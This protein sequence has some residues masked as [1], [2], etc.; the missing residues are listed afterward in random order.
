MSSILDLKE[1]ILSMGGRKDSDFPAA[2][3]LKGDER[4]PILQDNANVLASVSELLS[5]GGAAFH[6]VPPTVR[7]INGL[8]DYVDRNVLPSQKT[9]GSIFSYF[10]MDSGLWEVVRYK[11]VSTRTEDIKDSKNWEWLSV[12]SS[13]FK[14]LFE[15]SDRLSAV[16]R[17]PKVGDHA[18]VGETMVTS[19]LYKCK[20]DGFWS[21][22][23]KTFEDILGVRGDLFSEETDESVE[24]YMPYTA[25]MA[26]ADDDGNIISQTY[27]TRCMLKDAIQKSKSQISV[28]D[29]STELLTFLAGVKSTGV[30]VNSED[31]KFDDINRLTFA[32]RDESNEDALG[33]GYIYMRRNIVD[34]INLLEQRM[35]SSPKTIYNIR[36][37]YDL[38]GGTITIPSN[39]VL[40]FTNGGSFCNGKVKFG[41]NVIVRIF[42]RDQL[43]V[44]IEGQ[45]FFMEAVKMPKIEVPKPVEPKMKNENGVISFSSD[46]GQTWTVLLDTNTLK[47]KIKAEGR[48]IKVSSDNGLTWNNLIDLSSL[49]PKFK[50]EAGKLKVSNDGGVTWDDMLDLSTIAP[51]PEPQPQPQPRPEPPTPNPE[52]PVNREPS[53]VYTVEFFESDN[54]T[55][56]NYSTSTKGGVFAYRVGRDI[57][58]NSPTYNRVVSVT[59]YPS[60]DKNDDIYSGEDVVTFSMT[61]TEEDAANYTV[62]DI[63]EA[64]GIPGGKR[65]VMKIAVPNSVANEYKNLTIGQLIEKVGSGEGSMAMLYKK[66]SVVRN[67]QRK[68]I[69]RKDSNLGLLKSSFVQCTEI[70]ESE[71]AN[72]L[73]SRTSKYSFITYV[74]D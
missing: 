54:I 68:Y 15:S 71:A 47:P 52:P 17:S 18:F 9:P 20:V 26:I 51:K 58:P 40:D 53:L 31:L 23:G 14:G 42:N 46:N 61:N 38:D 50:V 28:D 70:E 33:Y 11:G 37:K 62:L 43:C 45:P 10:D 5:V 2:R 39:T 56:G 67:G 73:R 8:I 22:A 3:P 35:V 74:Q 63:K 4:I 16:V 72:L 34:G 29:L 19:T 55:V 32:D 36:Y 66:Y 69:F 21:P 64:A 24:A 60:S 30:V 44:D 1:K 49:M 6:S 7:S 13:S 12:G 25:D 48:F 59:R 57:N 27:V 41:E 65:A